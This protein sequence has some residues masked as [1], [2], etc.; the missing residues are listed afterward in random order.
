MATAS[1]DT[2]LSGF[3]EQ[4][5]LWEQLYEQFAGRLHA[6]V[7]G[8]VGVPSDAEDI[9]QETMIAALSALPSYSG[10]ARVFTWLC[11]IARHKI[12]DHWRRSRHS[13]SLSEALAAPMP[14]EPAGLWEA[15]ALM[16]EGYRRALVLRY[17]EGLSVAETALRLGRSYKATES[18]LSR[19]REALRE[20]M[21]RA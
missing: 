19:A 6:F 15:L 7:Y 20:T 12:A 11:G 21:S 9:V 13:C 17:A 1:L 16:P 8:Y 3:H 5:V 14:G 10:Q 18:L 4:G 2:C